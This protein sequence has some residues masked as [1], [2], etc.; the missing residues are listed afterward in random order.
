VLQLR[1]VGST[2]KAY[3]RDDVHKR[4][5]YDG[6]TVMGSVEENY[7]RGYRINQ[8]IAPMSNQFLGLNCTASTLVR[9]TDIRGKDI[10]CVDSCFTGPQRLELAGSR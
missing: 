6:K 2:C 7:R 1:E 5:V 10:V 4:V 8:S 9:S 3:T